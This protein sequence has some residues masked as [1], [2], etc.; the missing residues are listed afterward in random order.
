MQD[1]RGHVEDGAEA[2]LQCRGAPAVDHDYFVYKIW[3]LV[4][5]ERTE[6]DAV[7]RDGRIRVS[8]T[9]TALYSPSPLDHPGTQL[10]D[11]GVPFMTRYAVLRTE[12]VAL[13]TLRMRSI[14]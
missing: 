3:V 1:T 9:P 2:G 8:K 5:Q 4:G 11:T 7:G 6:G 12:P 10:A 14:H 13:V